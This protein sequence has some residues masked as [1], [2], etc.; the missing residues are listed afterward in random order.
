MLYSCRVGS[1]ASWATDISHALP[2]DTLK[3]RPIK[4]KFPHDSPW[5]LMKRLCFNTP[6][7]VVL[8]DISKQNSYMAPLLGP[9]E[10]HHPPTPAGKQ[11]PNSGDPFMDLMTTHFNTATTNE[12]L[13]MGLTENY[14]PTFLS[15]GNPCLD[16]FFHVVPDTPPETLTLRL[17]SA[18]DHNPLTTLKLICQL[19]GVRGTGK[20]DKEG[21]YTAVLWLH[22]NHPKTLALNLRP[23]SDFG[24][25]KDLPEILFRLLEGPDVRRIAERER[26]ISK[27]S[28]RESEEKARDLRNAKI[29]SMAI[30]VIGRYDRDPD[31]H[32]LHYRISDLFADLLI[33]DIQ[34]LNSGDRIRISLAAKWCPSIDSIF[35]QCT[36]ICETIARLVFPRES[37]PNYKDLE[38][39]YYVYRI[40]DRLRKQ[41][42]VPLRQA[43]ELPEV[44]MSSNRWDSLP[45]E[46][47]ASVAMKNYKEL[48]E[49]HDPERFSAFLDRV[50]KG[51]AKIAAGALLPHQIVAEVESDSDSEDESETD[52]VAELQWRRMVDDLS[53]QGKL[54]NCLAVC[55]VSGSMEGR[56]M[57][58]CVALGLLISELSEDPWKGKVITFSSD[59]QLHQIKGETLKEK[60]RFVKS[61]EWGMKTDFQK[62]FD[63]ILEIAVAGKLE[64]EKMVKR[65]FV[66]SDMEFD[67]ARR[68]R[69]WNEFG[70]WNKRE[71]D[72]THEWETDYEA[73][74]RK[75]RESGYVSVPEM[76]FWNLRDSRSTPVGGMAKGVS[77]VSGYSKNLLKLFLDGGE[78]PNPVEVMEAAISGD[79]YKKLVVFD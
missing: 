65:I 38:E 14:S 8:G 3:L 73:I 33:S 16:F 79:E 17:Q 22:K 77:L 75:F 45:Y 20:S 32:F 28:D 51:K 62:V 69:D 9:P 6:L 54:T 56:P 72:P 11:S 44:F 25:L 10:I 13:P 15:S 78:I 58:V 41:I 66:F 76:V 55:D 40:R 42:L 35:D 57:D 34:T 29:A 24:Y 12:N 46:R 4:T 49:K 68:E 37:D 19:R 70:L 5:R 74:Q 1:P 2:F 7:K 61:M 63:R 27:I 52:S 30:R 67:D 71:R 50:K 64:D 36:L 53:K 43:L 39:R 26:W 18:W 21:F 48:F 47:V 60:I 59:P 23:I 31:Y